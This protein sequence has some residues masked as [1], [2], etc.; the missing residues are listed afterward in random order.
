[1]EEPHNGL[2]PRPRLFS[3]KLEDTVHKTKSTDAG[4]TGL[5]P[6]V[7]SVLRCVLSTCT[8]LGAPGG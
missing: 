5:G 7:L 2:L 8:G 1:M 3:W 4:F 6:D